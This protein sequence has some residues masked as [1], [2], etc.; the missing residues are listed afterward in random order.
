MMIQTVQLNTANLSAACRD[1]YG[2]KGNSI[3]AQLFADTELYGVA[4]TGHPI[5]SS[6]PYFEE[7][8]VE[9]LRAKADYDQAMALTA[10]DKKNAELIQSWDMDTRTKNDFMGVFINAKV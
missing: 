2:M 10:I 7:I 5:M 8:K 1:Y 3:P 4:I 9:G 6:H